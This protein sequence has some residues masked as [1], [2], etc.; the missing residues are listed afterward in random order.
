MIRNL[1]G[2][3]AL[4]I[5]HWNT[6]GSIYGFPARLILIALFA[7]ALSAVVFGGI[8]WFL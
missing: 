6:L 2:G 7:L 4:W 8:V 3:L 1:L 5:A